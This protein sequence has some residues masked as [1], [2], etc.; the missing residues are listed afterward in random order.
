MYK[1]L[2]F[3]GCFEVAAVYDDFR[4]FN[5]RNLNAVPL[6][7]GELAAVDDELALKPACVKV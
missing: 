6:R 5:G 4:A 1:S 3:T 2:H 7:T